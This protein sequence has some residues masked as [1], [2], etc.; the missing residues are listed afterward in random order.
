VAT[1]PDRLQ[2]AED[3][4]LRADWERARDLY[5][6]LLEEDPDDPEALDGLGMISWWL[7]GRGD[8]AIE[9]RQ[10]AYAEFS[11]R[12][13]RCRAAGIAVYIG[14]EERI[15][16]NDAAGR[17]WL[18]RAERLLEGEEECSERGWLEVE[19]AKR[20]ASAEEREGHARAAVEIAQRLGDHDLE[21]S[22]LAQ[23]GLARTLGGAVDEGMTILDEAMAAATGGEATD[24]LAIGDACC[25]T[26]VA[27]DELADF[28]RAAE[29]CRIV[30][31]F[32]QRRN[33]TPLAAWCRTIYAGVLT[34]TGD[35]EVAEQQLLDSL[36]TYERLGGG[37]REY[38][39][40]G[41][42]ELRIR[43]GRLEEAERLLQG[44]SE[45]PLALAP[46]VAL[47][48]ERGET[49]LAA[50]RVEVRMESVPKDS[51]AAA[52]LLVLLSD[53]RIAQGDLEAARAAV[54]GLREVA[55]ALR[56]EHLI[57]AAELAAARVS[58]ASGDGAAPAHLKAAL[59]LFE[60]LGMPLEGAEAR[61]ELARHH[62][63]C[64]SELAVP[65]A[66]AAL[67]VFERLGAAR[68]ADAAAKVLR[69]LGVSG[70][71]V[72][73]GAAE[74]TKREREVLELLGT[75]LSNAEIGERLFITPKTAEHHVGRVL[76][77]LGLRNRTEAAAYLL[78][79]ETGP[80]AHAT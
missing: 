10:R 58:Q 79:G 36:R 57:A 2:A 41:L 50:E 18:A 48:L 74:L 1:D 40:A 26:L 5:S 71:T 6:E 52:T 67:A 39:L 73:R 63:A 46:M 69:S 65:E 23:L 4:R 24:P 28:K 16:G 25:M 64:G 61:L 49:A 7:T 59:E 68:H 19:R 53:V 31:E 60:R 15:R 8:E 34:T 70:R 42:A 78:R 17:G 27:C 66:R 21:V 76:S 47:H 20:A 32:T 55:R 9:L 37:H 51:P 13:D 11:R 75:G 12:G 38:A 80:G 44:H 72:E 62:A 77:K 56:R 54:E 45:H 29:W 30:V 35:W 3:A 22:S 33:Y 14:S 43:Q